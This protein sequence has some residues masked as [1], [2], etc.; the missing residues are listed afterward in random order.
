MLEF[1]GAGQL[2]DIIM[3]TS[4]LELEL[5]N[6]PRHTLSEQYDKASETGDLYAVRLKSGQ[7]TASRQQDSRGL[8]VHLIEP[9]QGVQSEQHIPGCRA[10]ISFTCEG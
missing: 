6:Q 10:N 8:T 4:G 2:H 5:N 3:V 1:P 9:R 7:A